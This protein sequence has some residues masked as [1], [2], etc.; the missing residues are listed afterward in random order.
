MRINHRDI[1][2][3]APPFVIAEMCG[4]HNQPLD[5]AL[6]LVV[7]AADSGLQVLKQSED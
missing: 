7:A 2:L 4:N 1:G 3:G 6:K 5:P